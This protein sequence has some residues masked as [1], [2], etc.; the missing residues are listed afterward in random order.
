MYLYQSF[1]FWSLF[2]SSSDLRLFI[3]VGFS[4]VVDH[5]CFCSKKKKNKNKNKKCIQSS[6]CANKWWSRVQDNTCNF[7]FATRSGFVSDVCSIES[8]KDW[9]YSCEIY[10]PAS[11]SA[12]IRFIAIDGN[13]IL[14]P[15]YSSRKSSS[16]AQTLN[17][18]RCC[19]SFALLRSGI[20]CLRGARTVRPANSASEL[21]QPDLIVV[22]AR[23]E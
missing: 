9:G 18:I 23:L 16:Y 19:L 11:S 8:N 12:K 3:V 2:V 17:W 15:T 1:H 4:P 20:L 6:G 14:P 13:I 10:V 5:Y 21:R 7:K 22:E